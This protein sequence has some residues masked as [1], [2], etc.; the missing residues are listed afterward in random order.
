M[1]LYRAHVERVITGRDLIK[2]ILDNR[3]EDST[4]VFENTTGDGAWHRIKNKHLE[5]GNGI[6]IFKHPQIK[7]KK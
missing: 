4:L 6:L 2:F 7:R 1:P 5:V 3:I